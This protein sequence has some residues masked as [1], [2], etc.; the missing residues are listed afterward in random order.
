MT[1]LKAVRYGVWVLVAIVAAGIL[2]FTLAPRG[3]GGGLA[4]VS[5]GGPFTLT[6]Q[7]GAPVTE[8][9]LQGHPSALFFGY[10]FCPDVCP[11][12]LSDMTLWLQDLGAGGNK[13]KVYF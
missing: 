7:R 12:T 8:A 4:A 13:L 9:A 1:A 11:T 2:W 6:D 10:T 5:I 3:D